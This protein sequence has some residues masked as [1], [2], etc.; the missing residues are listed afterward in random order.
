MVFLNNNLFITNNYLKLFT[1]KYTCLVLSSFPTP[2]YGCAASAIIQVYQ[3]SNTP[4]HTHLYT[5][6]VHVE[7]VGQVGALLLNLLTHDEDLLKEEHPALLKLV[8]RLGLGLGLLQHHKGV[9]Q[10]QLALGC[11]LTLEQDGSIM[12]VVDYVV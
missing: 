8:V 2:T 5:G 10:Q 1:A 9:L 6:F 11:D 4:N 12:L 3:Q 7:R